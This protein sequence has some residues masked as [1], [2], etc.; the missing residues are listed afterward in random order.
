MVLFE[1][2]LHLLYEIVGVFLRLAELVSQAVDLLIQ[3][4]FNTFEVY[5]IA[6]LI[7]SHINLKIPIVVLL[8]V[9]V[10]VDT[11]EYVFLFLSDVL[12]EFKDLLPDDLNLSKSPPRPL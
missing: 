6:L 7:L 8:V 10:V 4:G 11:F 12:V 3:T 5:V 9:Y 2:L 1:E